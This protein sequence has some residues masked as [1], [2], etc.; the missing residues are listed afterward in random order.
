MKEK[1]IFGALLAALLTCFGCK[2]QI[3]HDLDEMR[4]NQVQLTLLRAAIRAEKD[5]SGKLWNISVPDADVANA[6]AIVERTRIL[7]KDLERGAEVQSGILQSSS[8]R[9]RALERQT[10]SST[11]QTLEHI[12]GVL[13][14]RV[15]LHRESET[16]IAALRPPGVP[17]DSGTASVLLLTSAGMAVAM[18]E[19]KT[20]VAGATGLSP[21]RVSLLRTEVP[22]L[23]I[24][25]AVSPSA[26]AEVRRR[27]LPL[28]RIETV[29]AFLGGVLA[30]GLLMFR[31]AGR[32]RTND[33][34][35]RE[36]ALKPTNGGERVAVLNDERSERFREPFAHDAP[37]AGF[38]TRRGGD[39]RG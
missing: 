3:L 15:H 31:Y 17:S 28:D 25:E 39:E 9:A 21:A 2:Q 1:G 27:A 16:P 8:E 33:R 20:L 12:P 6:L 22:E 32:R 14:A 11:E 23:P 26:A 38:L 34:T 5:R 19:V 29:A 7:R 10:A 35:L 24:G 30:V 18:D 37:G 36:A 4:A 13:E